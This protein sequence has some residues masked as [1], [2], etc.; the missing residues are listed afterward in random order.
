MLGNA[1]NAT[2]IGFDM[3]KQGLNTYLLLQSS[4]PSS[5]LLLPWSHNERW[6][7]KGTDY[8]GNGRSLRKLE[9]QMLFIFLLYLKLICIYFSNKKR[10][11]KL[12]LKLINILLGLPLAYN[13]SN[14]LPISHPFLP[15]EGTAVQDASTHSCGSLTAFSQWYPQLHRS[16]EVAEEKTTPSHLDACQ[17][18]LQFLQTP[19]RNMGSR[20]LVY[21]QMRS[22]ST[23]LPPRAS[24]NTWLPLGRGEWGD[25]HVQS[26]SLHF[27]PS[28]LHSL[29][30]HASRDP[31]I[32]MSRKTARSPKHPVHPSSNPGRGKHYQTVPPS[33]ST[34]ETPNRTT[35]VQKP[36]DLCTGGHRSARVL[37]HMETVLSYPTQLHGL[38]YPLAL[39]ACPTHCIVCAFSLPTGF[40]RRTP[41]AKPNSSF[42]QEPSSSQLHATQRGAGPLLVLTFSSHLCTGTSPLSTTQRSLILFP[43]EHQRPSPTPVA[44]LSCLPG[45]QTHF[46][47]PGPQNHPSGF[48]MVFSV[49]VGQCNF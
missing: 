35:P 23:W 42:C 40:C 41:G 38:Q 18:W 19:D 6:K 47:S 28:T 26:A 14:C 36:E 24:G 9:L 12:F 21:Y 8:H 22:K 17:I 3:D 1:C 10:I 43:P 15:R 45:L 13:T 44:A 32:T 31:K 34:A 30:P 2:R 4:V 7:P 20:L 39:S 33:G 25:A 27:A 48:F 49:C 29:H 37:F 16:P 46:R 5:S 11:E